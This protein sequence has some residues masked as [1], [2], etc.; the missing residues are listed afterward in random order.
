MW[1]YPFWMLTARTAI[2]G[3]AGAAAGVGAGGA[4][5]CSSPAGSPG[6]TPWFSTLL[7]GSVLAGCLNFLNRAVTKA[8]DRAGQSVGRTCC[9]LAQETSKRAFKQPP[10]RGKSRAFFLRFALH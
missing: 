2:L 3:S 1:R 4:A 10:R 5:A 8:A 6:E 7:F 9:P